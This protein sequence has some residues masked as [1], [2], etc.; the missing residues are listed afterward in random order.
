M[1][2]DLVINIS[3]FTGD[4]ADMDGTAAVDVDGISQID[5]TAAVEV[6]GISVDGTAVV[7]VEVTEVDGCGVDIED[8]G[9]DF[10]FGLV[11]RGCK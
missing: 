8:C 6:D 9:G 5:G 10:R 3:L 1:D 4:I 2:V 11:F 7:D